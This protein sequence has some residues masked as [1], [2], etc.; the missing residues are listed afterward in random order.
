MAGRSRAA[1]SN[2]LLLKNRMSGDHGALYWHCLG[3]LVK[4]FIPP[5][6]CSVYKFAALSSRRRRICKILHDAG[7]S[8]KAES[9]SI[10]VPVRGGT[11]AHPCTPA[12]LPNENKGWRGSA[13]G[14]GRRSGRPG[15]AGRRSAAAPRPLRCRWDTETKPP[16]PPC[17]PAVLEGDRHVHGAVWRKQIPPK[18]RLAIS[19]PAAS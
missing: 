13:S 9:Q 2:E 14:T 17:I 5:S 7:H 3:G 16:D 11:S 4:Q 12:A 10:T 6:L 15:S 1:Y 8:S 19:C 18:S